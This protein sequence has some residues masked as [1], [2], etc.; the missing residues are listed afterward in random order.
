MVR[1][2][3]PASLLSP[4]VRRKRRYRQGVNLIA[5]KGAKTF[6]D[7][8]MASERSLAIELICHD[9]RAKM[10]IIVALD[11]DDRLVKSGFDQLCDFR[12]IHNM[13]YGAASALTVRGRAV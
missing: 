4:L 1:K 7:Q 11:F 2:S 13:K 10:R 3:S 5:D 8:L 9:Q 12:W 6:I